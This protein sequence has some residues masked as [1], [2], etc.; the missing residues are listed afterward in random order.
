VIISLDVSQISYLQPIST[1]EN[2]SKV[3]LQSFQLIRAHL[4]LK[5]LLTLLYPETEQEN[6]LMEEEI[7][8]E[9]LNIL[10]K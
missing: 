10:E 8:R 3:Q 7:F 4:L 1:T 9:L 2:Q 6:G 5:E